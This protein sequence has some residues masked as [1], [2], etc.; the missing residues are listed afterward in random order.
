METTYKCV[1]PAAHIFRAYDIRGNSQQELTEDAVY[2]IARKLS[3]K[4]LG[5]YVARD[6]RL[7]GPK[8]IQALIAGLNDGGTEV[9]DLG[10]VPTPVL[11][12][13]TT[14]SPMSGIMLTASHN[15]APDNG[16]KIVVNGRPFFGDNLAN[17]AT[18][19]I[20][21]PLEEGECT[22]VDV[23]TEY[24]AKISAIIGSVEGLRVVVDAGNGVAGPLAVKL[25]RMIGA[26]VVPLYCDIDGN[27]PNHHPDPAKPE[28]L[29][30][31]IQRVRIE[32]AD[33]GI[34]FD[35]DG[36]R[37]GVVTPSGKMIYPDVLLTLF[38]KALPRQERVLF[39]VKCARFVPK[40]LA[41]FG[42]VPQMCRTG[43]AFIKEELIATEAALAGEMSGHFFMPH[44]WYGFDDAL[45]AAAKLL[46]LIKKHGPIETLLNDIPKTINTP[47]LGITV[48]ESQKK[49]LMEQ[50]LAMPFP[51]A[52]KITIDGLRLE[53]PNGWC[54]VRQSN[55][56]PKLVL[57]I[58]ADDQPAFDKI[59][60]QLTAALSQVGLTLEL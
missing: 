7:S 12:Y 55:T 59:K 2:T 3:P 24:L 16:L 46:Q 34:A 42:L 49:A 50:L 51:G 21:E 54:L 20:Q 57:R 6:G 39:D 41:E 27:F 58:E 56:T 37:L 35:G 53:Y 32:R 15:P 19:P 11:Y 44:W 40:R 45:F 33:V 5:A 28:N 14:R 22:S 1:E 43:H 60:S 23:T 30:D 26:E 13:A 8:L 31:L 25:L 48:E 17:L 38:A 9:H 52:E 4:M 29:R 47:E 18:A 36:D 10:V